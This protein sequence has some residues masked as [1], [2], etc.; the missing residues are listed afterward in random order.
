MNATEFKKSHELTLAQGLRRFCGGAG[1][2][3]RTNP[4]AQGLHLRSRQSARYRL[5]Q[6]HELTPVRRDCTWIPFPPIGG[7]N[8]VARTNPRAQGL[9]PNARNR[10]TPKAWVART[11]PRAQGLHLFAGFAGHRFFDVARLNPRAQGLHPPC[12]QTE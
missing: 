1:T 3:A 10:R 2:V 7:K 12:P 8:R 6:S 11:N 9:H 4:R 5:K